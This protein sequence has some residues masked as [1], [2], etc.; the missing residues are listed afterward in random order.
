MLKDV[1]FQDTELNVATLTSLL[2]RLIMQKGDNTEVS[3]ADNKR[4]KASL[5][6]GSSA[7]EVSSAGKQFLQILSETSPDLLEEY[8]D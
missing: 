8:L 2:M 1:A 7:K 5:A 3:L 6:F 4:V